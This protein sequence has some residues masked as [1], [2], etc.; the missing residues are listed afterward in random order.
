MDGEIYSY[1]ILPC[2]SGTFGPPPHC[3][4]TRAQFGLWNSW[5][6]ANFGLGNHKLYPPAASFFYGGKTLTGAES[7][8]LK[9][10]RIRRPSDAMLYMDCVAF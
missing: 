2:P 4:L 9:A 8:P 10:A 6:G 5:I 7:P 3:T 1:K